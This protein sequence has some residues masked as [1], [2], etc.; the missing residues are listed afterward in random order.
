MSLGNTRVREPSETAG[1]YTPRS[2]GKFRGKTAIAAAV[3]TNA[4]PS[5]DGAARLQ[6]AS[7][8]PGKTSVQAAGCA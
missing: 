2:L 5:T 3:A 4:E 1:N 6:A 8:A 7:S